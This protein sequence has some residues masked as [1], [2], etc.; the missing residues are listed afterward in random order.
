MR[1]TPRFFAAAERRILIAIAESAL[2]AGKYLPAAGERTVAAVEGFLA[3]LPRPA[4]AAYRA[5]LRAIDAAAW[6]SKR[7]GF[8][9]LDDAARLEVLERWRTGGV[10]R[11]NALRAVMTPLKMAH[12]DNRELYKQL[13]CVYEY[14]LPR[15]EAKPAY[16]TQRVHRGAELDADIA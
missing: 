12:L 7:R 6:L 14:K 15:A 8:V 11:R 13:G 16:M 9:R 2:P 10:A 4:L 3:P 5:T 1:E